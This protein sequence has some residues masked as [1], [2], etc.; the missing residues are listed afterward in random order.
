MG[1]SAPL[2]GREDNHAKSAS[3]RVLC[4]LLSR[5]PRG[6]G[7]VGRTALNLKGV[8]TSG[9]SRSR[10]P[11]AVLI[12]IDLR[13]RLGV[14]RAPRW[15]RRQ[16]RQLRQR[17]CA[18]WA[19]GR[20]ST[21]RSSRGPRGTGPE[22]CVH[23]NAKL[24]PPTWRDFNEDTPRPTAWGGAR[25]ALPRWQRRQPRQVRQC[26]MSGR[27]VLHGAKLALAARHWTCR[28]WPPR[29]RATAAYLA[30]FQ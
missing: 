10:Q 1:W 29:A 21:G 2:V 15:E 30:R 27:P 17:A 25:P 19:V 14:E 22:G 24:Q 7:R 18:P 26:S 16:P 20:F 9:R 23:V 3:V 11:V 12:K 28:V 4:G 5:T 13:Q 6:E 8:A